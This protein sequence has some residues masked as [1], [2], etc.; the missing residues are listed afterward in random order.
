MALEGI[1][2]LAIDLG[3]IVLAGVVVVTVKQAV[4]HKRKPMV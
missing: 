4:V 1:E 2:Q 3:P